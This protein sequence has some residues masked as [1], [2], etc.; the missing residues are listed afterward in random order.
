[1]LSQT[2]LD[3]LLI[4]TEIDSTHFEFIQKSQN[5]VYWYSH[6]NDQRIIRICK[7]RYRTVAQVEAEL[8]WVNH[9]A[10]CGIKTCRP[11]GLSNGTFLE[12]VEINGEDNILTLFEHAPGK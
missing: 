11:I 8:I 7:G 1:M 6:E 2:H 12:S 9:L 5:Y 10:N 4:P 3:L